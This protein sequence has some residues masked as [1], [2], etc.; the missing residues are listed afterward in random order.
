MRMRHYLFERK[1]LTVCPVAAPLAFFGEG[2][3][4]E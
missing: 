2:S 4:E 1:G 3:E